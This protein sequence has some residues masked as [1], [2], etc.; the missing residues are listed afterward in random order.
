MT[1]AE[2]SASYARAFPR[3]PAPR[4]DARWLDGVWVLG[5]D[6]RNKSRLYGAFPPGLLPRIFSLF[7]DA[8]SV[9]HLFSGSLTEEGVREAW[10]A[11]HP[12][13]LVLPR[14]MRM[15][16]ARMPEAEAAEPDVVGDAADVGSLP[17]RF[18]LVIADPP[19]SS[20]DAKRYG[21][22]LPNKK[23]VVS[24]IAKVVAPGGH[25]VWL[26]ASLPMFR[27]SEWEWFGAIGVVR[28]TNHRVRLLSMFRRTK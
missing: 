19:Y 18:D 20:E 17:V 24:E 26:D 25:L 1:L 11:A 14:Q 4:T 13:A 12:K 8:E 15:D 28:S 16:N 6:Y 22:K 7:P 9:L 3:W 21:V 27:K 5:N 23:R 2:R 10:Q